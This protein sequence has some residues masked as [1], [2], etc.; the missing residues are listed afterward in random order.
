MGRWSAGQCKGIPLVQD[1]HIEFRKKKAF[2][3]NFDQKKGKFSPKKRQKKAS[4]KKGKK[5]AKL[6]K[7]GIMV[8]LSSAQSPKKARFESLLSLETTKIGAKAVSS[9]NGVSERAF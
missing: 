2:C 1:D 5:K 3:P 8:T 6:Q 7:K 9:K 4:K